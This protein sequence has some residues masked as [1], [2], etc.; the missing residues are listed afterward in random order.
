MS[1]S[2]QLLAACLGLALV[3]TGLAQ[4]KK[5]YR[6]V[7]KSGKVHISDQLPP[8][9]VDQARKEYSASSGTLKGDVQH[10][11]T[12]AE[13]ALAQQQAQLEAEALAQ[14]EKAK[15]IEQGMMINFE[16]EQDLQRSF[17]E[18]TDLLQQTITSLKASIQSRRA[19]IISILNELSD[20][21]LQGKPLPEAKI[22]QVK[23]NHA[24]ITKQGAQMARL[25]KNFDALK[26][27]F[28]A[29]M[30]RYR[31]LKSGSAALALPEAQATATPDQTPRQ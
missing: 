11:L 29:T 2:N 12:P 22:I 13:R 1:K 23:S 30:E 9:A 8:E 10:Q 3:S 7:D 6:W 19:V 24:L 5:I 27:E 21:E 31:Q 15:R 25:S 26:G 14:A 18:R 28:A 16:T 20:L 4:E 17:D